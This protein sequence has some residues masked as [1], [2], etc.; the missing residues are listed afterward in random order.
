MMFFIPVHWLHIPVILLQSY[1]PIQ[2]NGC[3][4]IILLYASKLALLASFMCLQFK[5]IFGS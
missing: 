4:L 1:R 2:K 5:R 3:H